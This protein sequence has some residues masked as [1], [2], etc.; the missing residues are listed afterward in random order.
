M[1][2]F[3]GGGW[4]RSCDPPLSDHWSLDQKSQRRQDAH[5]KQPEFH[6]VLHDALRKPLH[7]A[8]VKAGRGADSSNQ[9]QDFGI[10]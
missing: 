8:S 10:C 3:V 6:G 4:E 2:R 5:E 7:Q 1:Q 9:S